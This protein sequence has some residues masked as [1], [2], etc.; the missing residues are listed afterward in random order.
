ME[1]RQRQGQPW[2]QPHPA[3]AHP[4]KEQRQQ[5][6]QK[7]GVE[8]MSMATPTVYSRECEKIQWETILHHQTSHMSHLQHCNVLVLVKAHHLGS[9][10]STTHKGDLDVTGVV[11]N[12]V[13]GDHMAW[14]STKCNTTVW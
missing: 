3:A 5:W 9:I 7:E 8:R 10:L 11:N 14:V 2:Q 6:Q 1:G 4:P 12:M 13:V